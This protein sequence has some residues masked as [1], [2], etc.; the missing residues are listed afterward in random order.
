M[1]RK[2]TR[3]VSP[4]VVQAKSSPIKQESSINLP[5]DILE[6]IEKTCEHR[7]VLGLLDDKEERIQRALRYQE[8]ING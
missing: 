4:E 5:P 2:Y 7:K 6:S 8:F 3:K 1:K